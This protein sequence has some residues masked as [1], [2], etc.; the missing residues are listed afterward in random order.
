MSIYVKKPVEVSAFLWTGDQNQTE[1]PNWIVEAIK[2]G[3]VG[4]A[5][6]HVATNEKECS[7]SKDDDGPDV[8]M[9][10]DT[11][12]GIMLALPGDYIIKGVHGEIY[13]CK[14]DIFKKTYEFVREED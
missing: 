14:P 6:G 13:P 5:R 11:L 8:V 4:F 7:Y 3:K 1:D 10:I 12:E 9:T 2:C